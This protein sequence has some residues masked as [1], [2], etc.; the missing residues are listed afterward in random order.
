MKP[1]DRR[2]FAHT[3]TYS[4]RLAWVYNNITHVHSTQEVLWAYGGRLPLP[5]VSLVSQFPSPEAATV[6]SVSVSCQ[7][8]SGTH[9][10]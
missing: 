10:F 9:G 8:F 7:G 2:V 6:T 3:H 4:V 1:F 5:P